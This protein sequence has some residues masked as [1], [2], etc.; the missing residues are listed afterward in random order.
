MS[1]VDIRLVPDEN[2]YRDYMRR[3]DRKAFNAAANELTKAA[4]SSVV[5]D[6]LTR[7]KY[8]LAPKWSGGTQD[9]GASGVAS[10]N[11]EVRLMDRGVGFVTWQILEGNRTP[12]NQYI[13][14]GIPPGYKAS[15]TLL[16][17]WSSLRGIT[18]IH[19]SEYKNKNTPVTGVAQ[20][21]GVRRSTMVKSKKGGMYQR[22][23]GIYSKYLRKTDPKYT[24]KQIVN[25]ALSAL[26][27]VLKKHGTERETA[28]WYDK[29]PSGEGRFDYIV[30]NFMR[31][32]DYY[33]RSTAKAAGVL[34]GGVIEYLGSGRFRKR[35]GTLRT[36]SSNIRG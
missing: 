4:G 24:P 34:A 21:A 20:I 28:N 26:M 8:L 13:R 5:D 7:L 30:Y 23:G 17:A 27:R 16:Q 15:K 3:L 10:E 35:V 19:P 12:A 1:L 31:N 11:F 2:K 25:A 22:Q 29:W 18:W 6:A 9:I 36:G 33:E 32:K 14:E